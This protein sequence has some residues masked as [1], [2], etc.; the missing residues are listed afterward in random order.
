MTIDEQVAEFMKAHV[1]YYSPDGVMMDSATVHALVRKA[2]TVPEGGA[3]NDDLTRAIDKMHDAILDTE[4]S[5]RPAGNLFQVWWNL[6]KRIE[7]Q[8]GEESK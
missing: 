2:L 8:N 4:A 3:I 7:P 5:G 6:K 1:R